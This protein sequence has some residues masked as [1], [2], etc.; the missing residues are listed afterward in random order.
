MA[1]KYTEE[2]DASVMCI[3]AVTKLG[4]FSYMVFFEFVLSIK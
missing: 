2:V 3:R 1:T 4:M